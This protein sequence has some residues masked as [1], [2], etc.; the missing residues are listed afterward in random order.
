MSADPELAFATAL[1]FW[2]TPQSPKPSCHDVMTG[3]WSPS[4][5]DTAAGRVPGF[6]L[7]IDIING[8]VECGRPT[9]PQVTDRIG[10]YQRAAEL[11]DVDPGANLECA[12]MQPYGG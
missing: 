3:A 9:P 6:G 2:M 4:A 8:G 12:T 11:L 1:W 10:Y 7:T 5:A